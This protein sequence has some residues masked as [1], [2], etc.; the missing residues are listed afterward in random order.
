VEQCVDVEE[1]YVLMGVLRDAA[2]DVVAVRAELDGSTV[3]DGLA[4]GAFAVQDAVADLVAQWVA[5]TDDV[6]D[7]ADALR[8]I[9]AA[10]AEEYTFCET[11]VDHLARRPLLD[12]TVL[13]FGTGP[14]DEG[15]METGVDLTVLR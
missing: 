1:I 13:P 2:E 11:R 12:L 7:A 9:V 8:A 3:A 4:V 14:D 6:A 15:P 5:R 10:A